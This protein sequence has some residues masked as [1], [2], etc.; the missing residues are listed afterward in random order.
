MLSEKEIKGLAN[1]SKLNLTEEEIPGILTD[2]EKMIEFVNEVDKV[3]EE[4]D[5]DDIQGNSDV[6]RE[7]EIISP[8]NREEI[9][10]NT[11]SKDG[12]FYIPKRRG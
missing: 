10:Q 2:L 9:L 5:F 6:L 11:C 1:L 8:M 4:S 7:D 3:N 12:F